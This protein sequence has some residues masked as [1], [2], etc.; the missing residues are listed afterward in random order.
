MYHDATPIKAFSFDFETNG[1]PRSP[2][3]IPRPTSFLV[4]NDDS[5]TNDVKPSL[6]F[7][8]CFSVITLVVKHCKRTEIPES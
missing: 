5:C 8:H 2:V 7:L 4:H 1:D 6:C 3:Q